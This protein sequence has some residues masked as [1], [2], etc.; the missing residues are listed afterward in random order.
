MTKKT[1]LNI[2][3]IGILM[4]IACL[5]LFSKYYS[6]N[7]IKAQ[8]IVF[9]TLVVLEIARLYMIRSEYNIG[10]FSNKYLILAIIFSF[11][12]QLAV[13]YTPLKKFF[14]VVPLGTIEW[15]YI[16][17]ATIGVLITGIIS[18]KVIRKITKEAY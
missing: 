4:C 7:L 18:M 17:G 13:I 16:V 12:L 9:T 2:A 6:T 15:L 1:T 11:M 10:I 14:G 3:V 8:T 5:L